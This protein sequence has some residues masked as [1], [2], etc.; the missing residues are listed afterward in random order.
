MRQ[1]EAKFN[2]TGLNQRRRRRGLIVMA[3]GQ[4]SFI[5]KL[6]GEH[7]NN[8]MISNLVIRQEIGEH[9][10]CEL[11]FRLL[12]QQR[13]PF[14]SY[15]GKALEFVTIGDDGAEMAIF[16]GF[17]LH[18]RLNYELHGVYMVGIRAVT[19]SYALQLTPE[20]NYFFK[21]D[22]REVAEKVLK[23]D[24]L[25]LE[26]SASGPLARMNYVQWEETDFDFIRRIADD[27]GCFIRPTAGGLEIR[28]GF[29]NV[30]HRLCW[31]DEYGLVKFSLE[32]S[33]GQAS[34]DGTRYDP[35]TMKSRTFRNIKQS[36]RFFSET[37]AELVEAVSS[38]SEQLPADRLV[39][40]GRAPKLEMYQALL[41]KESARSIGSKILGYGQSRD[42]RLKPGDQVHLEGFSF[43]AQ[44]DYGLIKV[45]HYYDMSNGYRNEITVTPWKDYT[46]PKQPEPK[47]ING[48]VPARVVA[49]NDLRNM[50]RIKIQYDWMENS[51]TAWA[52]MV[53]PSAGGGRGF[54]FMPEVGDEVLVAFEY[55]DPERPYIVGALWNG[56]SVAP[57]L[58]YSTSV[59]S[60]GAAAAAGDGDAQPIQVVPQEIAGNFIKRIVTTSGHHIQFDD[61]NG[62]ESIV[63]ATA[64]GQRIQIMDNCQE[65]GGRQMLCLSTDGDILLNAP[66]GRVHLRSKYFSREIG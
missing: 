10:W 6:D 53:T 48:V 62:Q 28:K 59:G 65:T 19:R 9:W 2:P 50:G 23:Q 31:H 37:A 14:E 33:L 15:I 26:F 64:G 42:Y 63:V 7:L 47:R 41:E 21:K 30:G 36:P 40:D 8:A 52:R 4:G 54:M 66:N 45:V 29:Q 18:G 27:Q 13:P 44:G 16:D 56:V 51:A 61:S 17:V 22:L 11:E 58:G 46:S 49:H 1:W 3:N 39:F 12:N 38:Q 60:A 5:L 55:G 32:G 24:K 43:D 35:R 34:F 20:E 57:R 25:E